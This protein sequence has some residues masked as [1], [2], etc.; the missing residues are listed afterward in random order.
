MSR[1]RRRVN[2]T[3]GRQAGPSSSLAASSLAV[4]ALFDAALQ[5]HRAGRLSEAEQSYRQVLAVDPRHA[6]SLHFLGIIAHGMGRFAA[7]IDLIGE[8]IALRKTDP[9]YYNNLGTVL[10]DW[11]RV[12]EATALYQQALALKPD[13]AA[14]HNNL[15][16][17]LTQQGKLAEATAHYQ[18]ALALHPHYPEAHNNLASLLLEQCRLDEAIALYERALAVRPD[19]AEAHNNLGN[20][21]RAGGNL[22]QAREHYRRAIA[23]KPDYAEAYNNLGL[24]LRD[25]GNLNE[26]IAHYE[27]A[28]ALKP[29]Y[30]QVHNNL[31]NA[32][33]D[34]GRFAD[35]EAHYRRALEVRPDYAEVYSN[36]GNLLLQ[37]GRL[38][39]AVAHYEHALALK[40]DYAQAYNNLG[41]ALQD[42]GRFAE[43]T[44]NYQ[45]AIALR[46]DY[47]EAYS[48]LG[49]A[50]LRQGKPQE[51]IEH[52]QRALAYKPDYA[53][54]YHNMGV[55]LQ[56][57]GAL[58][59]AEHAH[60][61]AIEF[62]PKTASYY[63][64]LLN[65]R[66]VATGDRYLA[67][68]EKLAEDIPLLSAG[69]R[70]ELH[71][72]LGKAYSDLH[73]YERSFRHLLIGNTLKRQNIVYD[74]KGMFE[75]FDRIRGVFTPGLMRSGHGA[76]DASEIPVFIVGMP[77]S[78]TTLIEQ[79]LASHP[80]VFGA[81]ERDDF[82]SAVDCCCESVESPATFP[83]L[84]AT[85]SATALRSLGARYVAAVSD[86]APHAARIVNKLPG[87]FIYAGLI[88]LAL[89]NARII[90][91]HRDPIDTCFSCFS[92]LFSAGQSQCYDLGELGRFY[93]AYATVMRHWRH[94]LPHG[95]MLEVRYEDV[96]V[97]F[98]QQARRIVAYCGL[99][100]DDACLTFYKTQ[101]GVETASAAQVRKPIYRSSI[102]RWRAYGD[103][104]QPLI[105]ELG[106]AA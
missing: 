96:V 30:A 16:N 73:Q 83:E 37:R 38:E 77:R 80:R 68:M 22:E 53:R 86:E 101:R 5:Q 34:Q 33:L 13:Y 14:A 91:M 57:V 15:G 32:L 48:N 41:S 100:W 69:D 42:Q 28:L 97:D 90:H 9:S 64:S 66:Q 81:G 82:R 75:F 44:A 18:R 95:A 24:A 103:L 74:E 6:D 72:A 88:H 49:N 39:E 62:A 105:R 40:P 61:K 31:G 102:G 54:A 10:Q 93:R 11:G 98:E 12:A 76:G 50:L 36:L 23:L 17:A 89:P 47:A 58:V 94:V 52:H 7:A 20:A 3:K 79:I 43:A 25:Q 51:A 87:N 78:G 2:A 56:N 71:F 63:R 35:A 21:L 59:E 4:P 60:E 106:P 67:A 65:V 26:A 19:Y 45:R 104:L 8:A 29:D 99:E 27:R 85:L 84:A 70:Q 1:K 55:A 92:I 46:P